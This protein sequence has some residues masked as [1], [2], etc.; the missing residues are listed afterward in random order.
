MP[1]AVQYL[2][3]MERNLKL[4]SDGSFLQRIVRVWDRVRQIPKTPIWNGYQL[5]FQED[6]EG[7]V[8]VV[9]ADPSEPTNSF[10]LLK[11]EMIGSEGVLHKHQIP[12]EQRSKSPG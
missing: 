1:G 4:P 9:C 6:M 7:D 12:E 11:L 8:Y 3:D 2:G 10:R 5:M